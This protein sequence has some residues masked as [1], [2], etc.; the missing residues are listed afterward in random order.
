MYKF[1]T[2]WICN[3]QKLVHFREAFSAFFYKFFSSTWAKYTQFHQKVITVYF[4]L[5][6]NHGN[7]VVC[8]I[9]APLKTWKLWA[10]AEHLHFTEVIFTWQQLV[11]KKSPLWFHHSEFAFFKNVQFNSMIIN[12]YLLTKQQLKVDQNIY[13][14]KNADLSYKQ[15]LLKKLSM[16]TGLK[17]KEIFSCSF[18]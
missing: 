16:R 9:T 2:F 13:H 15:F 14:Q 1:K 17:G 7:F 10:N 12:I 8:D 11:K 4:S 18:D 3:S 6:S 5:H